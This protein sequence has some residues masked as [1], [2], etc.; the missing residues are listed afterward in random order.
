MAK[1]K[2]RKQTLAKDA[3]HRLFK[4]KAAVIGMVW[5]CIMIIAAIIAGQELDYLII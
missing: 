3:L 2:Q 4:N 1:T 5:L